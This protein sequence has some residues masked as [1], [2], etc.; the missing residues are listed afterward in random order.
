MNVKDKNIVLT[1]TGGVPRC[2]EYVRIGVPFAQGEALGQTGLAVLNPQ[3]ELQPV[4]ASILKR[5]NDG[6]IKWGLFDFAASVPAHGQSIY[7]LVNPGGR[8]PHRSPVV[9]ITPDAGTWKVTTGAA[10]FSIDAREFRPFSRVSIDE[11]DIL[12]AD[13]A[14]CMLDLDEGS[15]LVPAIE[16]I[17]VEVAGPLRATLRIAGT[18]G[19]CSGL[20]PRFI[21]RLHFFAGS[22]RV[23]LEFTLR[24]PNR[25]LHPGGLWDL[26]DPGSLLF[27]ELALEFPFPEG[28]VTEVVCSPEQLRPAHRSIDPSRRLSI[29]QESSG[30]KNWKSPVHRNR[31][32]VVPFTVKGYEIRSGNAPVVTGD[33]ATPV[34]WCGDG[35]NGMAAVMPRFW[36]E[37]PKALE[38]DR[39]CLRVVLFPSRFPDMHELQGG[40][41][42]TTS[43]YLDFA[44]TAGGLA[45][46]RAPL[47]VVAAPEVFFSSGVI[48]DL[49][50]MSKNTTACDLIDQ[51][52]ARPEVL[53]NRREPA[54]EFGWRNFGDVAA[55]HEAA[56][57][58]GTETFISHYNNQYDVCSGLYRKFFATGDPIWGELASDLSRHVVDIDIYHTSSDRDEYNGGLFWHTDHYIPAGLSTHR[59]F[60]REHL[61]LKDPRF[62][63]GG[64]AA[65]HCYTTG[66]LYHYFLTGDRD[67]RDSV[68]TLAEW[69]IRSLV[70]SHTVLESIKRAGR[71]VRLLL[72]TRDSAK[73]AFPRYPLSRGTGNAIIACLD[74]FEVGGGRF[75]L[76]QA[77]A[78][79]CGAIHPRDDIAARGLLDAENAWSYTVLLAAVSRFI[80]KK[81]ELEEFD[82]G[83]LYARSCLLAYAEW[84]LQ[85]E[86]PYL[87]KPDILEYPNETWPAQDLRKSVILYQAARYAVAD[88]R[89][90][91]L[92]RA[93][94]FFESAQ[95]ALA[96]HTTS[97]FTRP[98]ALMLQ[99]GWVG[100]R[101]DEQTPE[102]P[103][104][105]VTVP[106]FGRP[107]PP[108]GVWS[109]IARIGSDLWGAMRSFSPSRE[110]AWLIIRLHNRRIEAGTESVTS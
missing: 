52:V 110:I 85:H 1:E 72:Q 98:V 38:A 41:Q 42:K 33:R 59:S 101:L 9:H 90:A 27:R 14:F 95:D 105:D 35:T 56:Y 78:L 23:I 83:Y 80:E 103:T 106:S 71:Y 2:G 11:R 68:I 79:L 69:C 5:W 92:E 34:I 91:F 53:V 45:W 3:Q 55:D 100:A 29:Y 61:R 25:A 26:G 51:F 107:T 18:F 12:T 89:K 28:Q 94:F 75:F 60:S 66:L 7:R 19:P 99:N 76:E 84:M 54:D 37:F 96:H 104:Y 81:G 86:Y 70:G 10:C 43:M 108:L 46:A 39:R 30:G 21:S 82:D 93:R 48:P 50:A 63:G 4:Q 97:G 102:M 36:Q 44:T 40:E 6:S 57:H 67:Y 77:E 65:E 62:C 73:P 87:D 13:A 31:S 58:H 74:A 88:R 15:R 8:S 32:G 22:S 24:N 16:S 49:P 17:A 20:P 64:P 109:V 47:T